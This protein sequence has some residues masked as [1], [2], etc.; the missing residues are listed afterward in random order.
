[1][2]I[3]IHTWWQKAWMHLLNGARN[4]RK[5]FLNVLMVFI[6]LLILVKLFFIHNPK[7]ARC[8]SVTTMWSILM[9]S[10]KNMVRIA[11]GCT[12]CSLDQLSNQNL[13][14]PWALKGLVNFLESFGPCFIM[15][16]M[17]GWLVPIHQKKILYVFSMLQ[18]KR[19]EKISNAFLSIQPLVNS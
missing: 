15:I 12:K 17:Y 5:L 9:M 18:L 11:S 14:I 4:M 2:V 7:S 16:R 13:G 6:R 8:P 19:P 10:L 1:M 3:L